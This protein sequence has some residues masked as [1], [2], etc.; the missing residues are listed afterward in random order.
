MSGKCEHDYV[1][2]TWTDAESISKK[3]CGTEAPSISSKSNTMTLTFKSDSLYR[4]K[5]F[6]C[7]YRAIQPNGIAPPNSFD[8]GDDSKAA[9]AA[10]AKIIN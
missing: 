4:Y 9:A 1:D 10:A 7:R 8:Y 2:I 3:F 6:V 5:G